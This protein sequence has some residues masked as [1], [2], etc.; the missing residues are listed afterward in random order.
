MNQPLAVALVIVQQLL[1]VAET[2]AVHQIGLSLSFSQIAFFR[3]IG[4]L[5]L[6]SA[7][8]R[9]RPF[10]FFF[11]RQPLLQV[12]RGLLSAAFLWVFGFT[13]SMLPL[14]DATALGYG[15]VI[16]VVVLAP[17]V[18]G[19]R[20]G[21][22]RWA[23][24]LVGLASAMLIIKPGF[25]SSSPGYLLAFGGA[26]L[27]GL[28]IVVTKRLERNDSA[29]T[30]ML[31]QSLVAVICFSGSLQAGGHV[32]ASPQIFCLMVLGPLGTYLG[33]LALRYSDASTLAPLS[34]LRLILAGLLGFILFDEEPDI[35]SIL[36]ATAIFGS[37]ALVVGGGR[38]LRFL[39]PLISHK[40]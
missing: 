17:L 19:E 1:F 31:W 27:N 35:L 15:S 22:A 26:W 39:K 10:R 5:L 11:T 6:V 40:S 16:C 3:G 14:A 36:G 21:I 8:S 34:Y 38:N 20:V 32:T 24:A 2:A 12:V 30:V 9:G 18:L 29:M 28:G 4:G 25:Q 33:I 7:L 13:Y 23:A 37:C